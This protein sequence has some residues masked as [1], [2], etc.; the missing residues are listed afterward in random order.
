MDKEQILSEVLNRFSGNIH[1]DFKLVLK[2]Q[3]ITE[4]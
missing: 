3:N 1:E 2:K 4:N